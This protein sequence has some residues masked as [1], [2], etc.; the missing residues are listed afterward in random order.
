MM[1][2]QNIFKINV[3]EGTMSSVT[4]NTAEQNGIK[5]PYYEEWL[6]EFFDSRRDIFP[7]RDNEMLSLQVLREAVSSGEEKT[8]Y[9]RR[10]KDGLRWYEVKVLVQQGIE[11]CLLIA[12]DIHEGFVDKRK[13]LR[14]SLYQSMRRNL[15][16]LR[17]HGLI[18]GIV[19]RNL[20][21]DKVCFADRR[22]KAFYNNPF[23][24][25]KIGEYKQKSRV[26]TQAGDGYNLTQGTYTASDCFSIEAEDGQNLWVHLFGETLV[27]ES[28]RQF[29]YLRYF[30]VPL[31]DKA[32]RPAGDLKS[33]HLTE[34][35]ES[36]LFEWNIEDNHLTLADNW[37][38]KFCA[39]GTG[40]HGFRRIE[41]YVYKDDI[42]KV[43]KM[44]NS[45]LSGDIEDNIL[46]RF[47]V[48]DE[49]GKERANWC[50][51][52]LI[53]VL[54]D[55]K[56][57]MYVVGSVRDLSTKLNMVM[58]TTLKEHGVSKEM[59]GRARLLVDHLICEAPIGSRH[60]LI[61]IKM[62]AL[63]GDNNTGMELL[64]YQYMELVTRMIYPDDIVWVDDCNLMLFLHNVGDDLNARKKAERICRILENRE[65]GELMADVGVAMFPEN[66]ENFD[67]LMAQVKTDLWNGKNVFDSGETVHLGVNTMNAYSSVNIIS[68]ILDEWYRTIK[69][70]NVLKERMELTKAQLLLSQI[71]PHFIYNVLANIKSLIYTD[72]DTAADIV[73]AFTKYLRVQL[74]AIAKEEM[75]P[76]TEILGFVRNYIEIE[77]SRFP[78][79]IMEY[80][81]IGYED[82]KMPHFILQPVV[83]NAIKHGICKREMPGR[84]II[85]SYLRDGFIVIEVED[86]GAGCDVS[87]RETERKDGGVGLENVGIRLHHLVKGTI[88]MESRLGIGTKIT[89]KIPKKKEE[90]Y[91]MDAEPVEIADIK[92]E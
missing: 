87:N 56:V 76:F 30:C 34:L 71:K 17:E 69:T 78:G 29:Q 10:G 11:D 60:A 77:K 2:Y 20:T 33:G 8:V 86:D 79:K 15:A 80:Y 52:S 6:E 88:K 47:F 89:I 91:E 43:R 18:C 64:I 35:V 82:F 46:A 7:T 27:M 23:F 70:N 73:V 51:I 14:I 54:Y 63:N 32:L 45:I 26:L 53:S 81:D 3:R 24:E 12:R 1:A 16:L 61:A 59:V 85:R 4:S 55:G 21:D 25:A 13:K 65:N 31:E 22:S 44:F 75:A 72:A 57:P 67:S 92:M 83:E 66:G 62:R 37:D 38:T 58:E 19:V 5:L 9:F 42:P 36:Y 84:L 74:N 41:R 40:N 39:A 90:K 68:D 48:S 49:H 50:S 28:G